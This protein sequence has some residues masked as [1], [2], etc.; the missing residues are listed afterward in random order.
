[1]PGV[2]HGTVDLERWQQGTYRV[3]LLVDKEKVAT[4]WF[5]MSDKDAIYREVAARPARAHGTD[6]RDQRQRAI[7]PV[8]RSVGEPLR[9]QGQALRDAI[10]PDRASCRLGARPPA[11]RH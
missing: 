9:R 3:D 2:G 1:C 10:S 11:C 7:G 4:G 6:R 5:V 8:L